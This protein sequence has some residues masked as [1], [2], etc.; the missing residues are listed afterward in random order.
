MSS[1][2]CFLHLLLYDCGRCAGNLCNGYWNVGNIMLGGQAGGQ[3]NSDIFHTIP[4]GIKKC[5]REI[6]L[7]LLTLAFP[8]AHTNPSQH[9]GARLADAPHCCARSPSPAQLLGSIVPA[10]KVGWVTGKVKVGGAKIG[11]GVAIDADG[12]G[13]GTPISSSFC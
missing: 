3:C 7:N 8:G 1:A 12:A 11:G 5:G 13:G 4:C 9:I 6:C 10:G 2:L